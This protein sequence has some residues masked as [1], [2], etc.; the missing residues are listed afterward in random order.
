VDAPAIEDQRPPDFDFLNVGVLDGSAEHRNWAEADRQPVALVHDGQVMCCISEPRTAELLA[1]EARRMREAWGARG[2]MMSHDEVRTLNWDDSCCKRK[3]D[4]GRI[5][6]ENV[7]A[8]TKL[9]EGSTVYVWSDMFDPFH[10]AHADYY[11]VRGDL[12]RSWEGLDPS[13]VIVNWNFGKRDDSLKFFADR[14][15]KQ[16]IAGHYDGKPEQA[17]EWLASAA[18]VRGVIGIMYTTWRQEY[19]DLEAFAAQVR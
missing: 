5:V 7:S 17:K 8:C 15:H 6:A 4:A 19:R 18:R 1:D 11:L 16:V 14:G 13:V 9:L 2:Y 3:L 12:A 10:N